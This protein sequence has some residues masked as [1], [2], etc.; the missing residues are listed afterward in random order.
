MSM[1]NYSA[2]EYFTALKE[3][4]IIGS[5]CL[6]C[7]AVHLPPRAICDSCFSEAMEEVEFSGKGTLQAYSVIYVPPTAM[8]AAGYGRENPNCAGI[9]KL[10]EGPMV[11]AQILGMDVAHPHSIQIGTSL[12]A[13]FVERGERVFLA[14]EA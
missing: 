12:Q 6:Q 8:I 1:T 7:G 9:V 13:A 11:S 14:F 10:D 3:K 5:R 4:K 2:S